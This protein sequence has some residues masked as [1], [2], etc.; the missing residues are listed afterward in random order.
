[1]GA[2][3][4]RTPLHPQWLLGSR[5]AHG[6]WV[7]RQSSGRVLDIGC[8]DRWIEPLLARGCEYLGLDYSRAGRSNYRARPDVFA[9]ACRL[10]FRDASLDTVVILE[11]V[12]HLP[13]PTNAFSEISRVLKPQGR[14]LL[15]IPFLYPIHDAPHDY[16][17]YTSH[18]LQRE[19]EAAGLTVRELVPSLGSAQTAGLV[20]CLAIGGMAFE[21]IRKRS[22]AVLLLPL[23]ALSLPII[24]L[25]AWATGELFPS[26]D[27]LTAGYRL[28]A[29][30]P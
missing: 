30:K 14:L 17:R 22:A 5:Q 9:D 24:N 13:N 7:A 15:T 2:R 28:A 26:W 27:A 23:M 16:Q 4:R 6:A 20:A 19:L 3:L 21:A 12:E 8:A 10:P 11:V 29:V 18:G 1:M 25:L